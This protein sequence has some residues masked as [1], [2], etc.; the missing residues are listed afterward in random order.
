MSRWCAGVLGVASLTLM[1]GCSPP[2]AGIAAAPP[3]ATSIAPFSPPANPNV[4]PA[5]MFDQIRARGVTGSDESIKL[6][7]VKA[8][9]LPILSPIRSEAELIDLMS[10][11]PS[12]LSTHDAR[13]IVAAALTYT[14]Q[15]QKA[16]LGR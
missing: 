5:D 15:D 7:M 14:C 2:I 3:E 4:E 13:V 11:P 1:V 6:D 12:K 16:K 8:C 10:T 9:M